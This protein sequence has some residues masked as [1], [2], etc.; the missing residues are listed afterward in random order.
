MFRLSELDW[1][2]RPA[3]AMPPRPDTTAPQP[4]RFSPRVTAQIPQKA[5]M[6]PANTE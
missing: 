2:A 5:A 6:I 3:R 1:I 4:S